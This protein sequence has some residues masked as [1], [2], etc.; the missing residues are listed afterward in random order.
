MSS[1][2]VNFKKLIT[3]D[4]IRVYKLLELLQYSILLL[5]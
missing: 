4:K 3:F 2:Q 5:G 1:Q